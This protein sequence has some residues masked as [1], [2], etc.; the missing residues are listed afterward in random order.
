MKD[1]NGNEIKQGDFVS[2]I[3]AGWAAEI[4]WNNDTKRLEIKTN[5]KS[6]KLNMLRARKLLIIS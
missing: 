1:I 3:K 6:W 2:N 5:Q 4:V